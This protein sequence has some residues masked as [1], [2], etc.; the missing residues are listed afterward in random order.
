M[1]DI[2][3]A[4]G[5]GGVHALR[6]LTPHRCSLPGNQ[7]LIKPIYHLHHSYSKTQTCFP[8]LNLG[9]KNKIRIKRNYSG[10]CVDMILV[11]TLSTEE[12]QGRQNNFILKMNYIIKRVQIMLVTVCICIVFGTLNGF[13]EIIS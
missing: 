3:V 10:G 1:Y 13:D 6:P 12:G 11:G 7:E 8:T 2:I 4:A 5:W 9:R